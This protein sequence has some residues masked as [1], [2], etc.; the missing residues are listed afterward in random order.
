MNLKNYDIM[1]FMPRW[2]RE[3]ES[4]KGLC[5]AVQ[6]Q[7]A[8]VIEQIQSLSIYNYIDG[9]TNEILDELAWQFHISEYTHDLPID[10]KRNLVKVAILN[11]RTRGTKGAVERVATD[12]FGESKVEEWFDYGGEPYHFRVITSNVDANQNQAEAFRKT[13]DT[14]KNLRSV[15]EEILIE[16]ILRKSISIT[17]EVVAKTRI[18][19]YGLGYWGLGK[20]SFASDEPFRVYQG[21]LGQIKLGKTPFA[22]GPKPVTNYNY[23]LGG[24]ILGLNPFASNLARDY[25]YHLGQFQLG[26][27][28]FADTSTDTIMKP[29]EQHSIQPVLKTRVTQFMAEQFDH[30]QV[31]QE[32]L[33]PD[34]STQIDDTT[35]IVTYRVAEGTEV[36]A[37]ELVDADG[38]PLVDAQVYIPAGV[39][40]MVRNEIK[41]QEGNG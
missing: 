41:I 31:N 26:T 4:A 13:I 27:S 12:I 32:I 15:L 34:L 21:K 23:P 22:N 9:Q 5:Y 16:V 11:Q 25:T 10:I 20:K 36:T 7:L 33:I 35:M 40:T 18:Y 3:D 38:T 37:A 17:E 39:E 29:E 28:A 2:M 30:V 19:N 14:T 1:E 8:R 24:M 6:K